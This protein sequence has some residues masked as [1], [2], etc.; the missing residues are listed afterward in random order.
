[1]KFGGIPGAGNPTFCK[2][3]RWDERLFISFDKIME[4]LSGYQVDIYR[5]GTE[6]AFNR[7]EIPAR[8]IGYEVL[9]RAV[10]KRADIYLE[11][12]GVNMPH[13]VLIK[14]LKKRGYAT[15]MYF[16]LCNLEIACHRAE[17]REKITNRHTS[18]EMIVKRNELVKTYLD[19]YKTLVDDLYIY[20]TSLNKFTLQSNYLKGVKIK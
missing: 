9:R 1:M 19:R 3:S 4:A 8:I 17:L 14:N 13:T 11:H 15:E 10:E 18:R 20:D 16:I 6:E 7:W 5:Q 2:H 12:S